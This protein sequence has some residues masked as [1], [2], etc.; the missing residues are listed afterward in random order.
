MRKQNKANAVSQ[1]TVTGRSACHVRP[2]SSASTDRTGRPPLT[3]TPDDG[4]SYFDNLTGSSPWRRRHAARTVA[5]L[6]RRVK[7]C[8]PETAAR[9]DL[10]SLEK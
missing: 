8:M 6:L 7:H 1:N 2:S 10:L 5:S 3:T 4:H 9:F